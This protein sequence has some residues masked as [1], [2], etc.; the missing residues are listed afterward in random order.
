MVPAHIQTYGLA[1]NRTWR[2]KRQCQ[3]PTSVLPVSE[4]S[5]CISTT[6]GCDKHICCQSI[7]SKSSFGVALPSI[8]SGVLFFIA[9]ITSSATKMHCHMS[10]VNSC[11]CMWIRTPCR[12]E[13]PFVTASSN[14]MHCQ[15]LDL[16]SCPHQWTPLRLASATSKCNQ[17]ALSE[18]GF[19]PTPT[20]VDQNLSLAP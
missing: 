5:I 14:K 9:S 6:P 19:E 20:Y 15:K 12:H 13:H 11:L 2:C 18:V 7:I 17:K 16:H 1:C 4:H 8:T 10:N 3:S